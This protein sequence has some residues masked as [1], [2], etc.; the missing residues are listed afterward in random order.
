MLIGW[1]AQTLHFF[2][3]LGARNDTAKQMAEVLKFCE[4]SPGG[5]HST[6]SELQKSLTS[7]ENCTLNIANKL[8]PQQNYTILQDFIDATR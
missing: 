5:L 2:I 3:I 4:V 8:Y 7:T 1:N 6:F